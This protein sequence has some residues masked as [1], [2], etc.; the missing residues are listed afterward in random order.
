MLVAPSAIAQKRDLRAEIQA[1]NDSMVAAF[2][3]GN[4]LAVSRF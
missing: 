2:N 4:M 1:V 3:T